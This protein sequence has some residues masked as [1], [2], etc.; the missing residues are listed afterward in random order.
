MIIILQHFIQIIILKYILRNKMNS[1]NV[2][3]LN[4]IKLTNKQSII[5]F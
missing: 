5:S 4:V 3:L 1:W 2:I